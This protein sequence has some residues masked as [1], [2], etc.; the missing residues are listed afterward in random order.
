VDAEK[1]CSW[2]PLVASPSRNDAKPKPTVLSELA[3]ESAFKKVC[4]M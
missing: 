1:V 3:R 4:R 2:L